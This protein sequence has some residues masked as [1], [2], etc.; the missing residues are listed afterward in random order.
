MDTILQVECLFL[1]CCSCFSLCGF[2]VVFC[3]S[4][5]LHV[6]MSE[7]EREEKRERVQAIRQNIFDDSAF[8]T[9]FWPA[10]DSK[11]Q[12]FVLEQFNSIAINLFIK[13]Y[14]LLLL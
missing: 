5:M 3:G 6:G 10:F 11:F 8:H 4:I 9:N 2:I 14:H 12:S 1:A 13:I 7:R